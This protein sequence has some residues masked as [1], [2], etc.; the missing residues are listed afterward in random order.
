MSTIT[1][2]QGGDLIT[3]S[4]AVINDNFSALNTDKMETSVLDT[5]TALTANS[6]SKIATQKAVKAYADSLLNVGISTETTTGTT[7]SLSTNGTDRKSV[8]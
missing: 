7:H 8:V 5:D 1:T 2:L 3:D 4:R 6:D